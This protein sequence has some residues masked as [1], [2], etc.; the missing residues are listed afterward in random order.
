M[1]TEHNLFNPAFEFLLI[2][3]C[4]LNLSI[5]KIR[6]KQLE[7]NC[8]DKCVY[9]QVITLPLLKFDLV[10]DVKSASRFYL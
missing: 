3:R 5:K 9:T 7:L 8:N 2:L 6:N 10:L 1:E 4:F